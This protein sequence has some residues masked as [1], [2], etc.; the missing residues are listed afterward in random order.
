MLSRLI[1]GLGCDLARRFADQQRGC[2]ERWQFYQ[3]HLQARFL[4]SSICATGSLLPQQLVF[5]RLS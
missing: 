5:H 3:G 2:H 4:V 1:A